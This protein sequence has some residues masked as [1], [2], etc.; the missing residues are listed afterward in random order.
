M[1]EQSIADVIFDWYGSEWVMRM[2]MRDYRDW[3]TSNGIPIIVSDIPTTNVKAMLNLIISKCIEGDDAFSDIYW[4]RPHDKPYTG[5]RSVYDQVNT[6][7]IEEAN[8]KLKKEYKTTVLQQ[9]DALSDDSDGG[10]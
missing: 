4:V 8:A 2:I 6:V 3:A 9:M 5:V 10:Y 7:K 1:A